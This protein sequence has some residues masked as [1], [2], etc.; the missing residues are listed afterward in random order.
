MKRIVLVRPHGPRNVGSV[1]RLVANFG[2]AEVVLVRPKRP[3][4]LIHPDFEQMSHGVED[5]AEKVR[6]EEDLAAA[7][8]DVTA[9]YGFTARAR[10]HR[11]VRDWRSV[12]DE[13]IGRAANE[14]ETVALVFGSEENGLTGDETDLLHELVRFPTS[15]EHTSLNL[16]MSVGLV[17]STLFF[18]D[19]PSAKSEG[20]TPLPGRDRDFLKAKLMDVLGAQARS[21]PAKR[22][23]V[24]SVERIFARAPL[25]TRDARAWHLLA[26][27]LGGEK[28]PRD[29]GFERSAGGDA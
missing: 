26:R 5:I 22:D 13:L 10:D 11:V 7:L 18:A 16:A 15:T 20:S 2:P 17:L 27:A 1:V 12:T 14:S 29:Y 4:M 25:E 19:A 9:S 8:A 3:S 24:A 21:A 6:V 23:L 28:E